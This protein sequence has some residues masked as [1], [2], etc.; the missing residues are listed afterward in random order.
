M[1]ND[2]MDDEG[3]DDSD[4]TLAKGKRQGKRAATMLPND[5]ASPSPP[6]HP[7]NGSTHANCTRSAVAQRPSLC[8]CIGP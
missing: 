8:P 6:I 4:S 1:T 5:G 7:P 3:K 2:G